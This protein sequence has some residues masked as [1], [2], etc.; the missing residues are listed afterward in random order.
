[1]TWLN[2]VAI[3]SNPSYNLEALPNF[4][5]SLLCLFLVGIMSP[6]SLHGSLGT[7]SAFPI[8]LSQKSLI[9]PTPWLKP[10]ILVLGLASLDSV[11]RYGRVPWF[12][13][14]SNLWMRQRW[15]LHRDLHNLV[16]AS[17]VPEAFLTLP[18]YNTEILLKSPL[19][20]L[21]HSFSSFLLLLKAF[22]FFLHDF[23][24]IF[25]SPP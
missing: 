19:T 21:C 5:H 16:W 2:F 12:Y 17:S 23:I 20:K 14:V 10:P 9:I 11:R 15:K 3:S 1:M 13:Q 6:G 24:E 22:L 7:Q 18:V 4:S 8:L 25:S